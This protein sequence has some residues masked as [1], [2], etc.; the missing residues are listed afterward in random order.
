MEAFA[1]KRREREEAHKATMSELEAERARKAAAVLAKEQAHAMASQKNARDLAMARLDAIR[2]RNNSVMGSTWG[3][4][5]VEGRWEG[6]EVEGRW[7]VRNC[8]CGG[9][10]AI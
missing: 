4:N 1:A 7:E 5:G 2:R 3:L 10:S 9:S 8:V 6:R